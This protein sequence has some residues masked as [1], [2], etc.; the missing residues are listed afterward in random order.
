MKKFLAIVLALALVT[1]IGVLINEASQCSPP[2][3]EEI[4]ALFENDMP[5]PDTIDPPELT[6]PA[7][8]RGWKV[9]LGNFPRYGHVKK[10]AL[11]RRHDPQDQQRDI[12]IFREPETRGAMLRNAWMTITGQNP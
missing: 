12:R 6:K 9:W 1:A 4:Y 3:P 2:E 10:L 8:I 5:A 11:D 7:Q